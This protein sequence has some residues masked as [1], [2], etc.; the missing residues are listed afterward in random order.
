MVDIFSVNLRIY[1]V[2]RVE[3]LLMYYISLRNPK[4]IEMDFYFLGLIY[5]L[6][7]LKYF[8]DYDYHGNA[9]NIKHFFYVIYF[10]NFY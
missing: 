1:F 8:S 10:Y 2:F 6:N 9:K 5:V 3:I 7:I 4:N